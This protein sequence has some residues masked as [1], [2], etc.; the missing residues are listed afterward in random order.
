MTVREKRD[1]EDLVEWALMHQVPGLGLVGGGG[2]AWGQLAALGTRVQ[3]SR[4][5]TPPPSAAEDGDVAMV[6][7]AICGLPDE[8]AALV[9]RYGKTGR[10]PEGADIGDP[11]PRQ[12]RERNGRLC[13]EY[14]IP[15]N[16][17][18]PRVGPM[19]DMRTWSREMEIVR[20]D[21][22]Q[23]TLWREAL[24]SMV[25]PLNQHLRT[26]LA[27]GP[28][29][30]ET[31]WVGAPPAAAEAEDLPIIDD[32]VELQDRQRTVGEVR[33]AAQAAVQSRATDWTVPKKGRGPRRR[34]Q[35]D[36]APPNRGVQKPRSA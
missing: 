24:A 22:A 7:Q 14:A 11:V 12:L 23:W 9:V 30:P 35:R 3:T 10:R 34:R 28:A 2:D 20:F 29:A 18:S 32:E 15:G 31:P 36:D 5:G 27:T 26:H 16:N 21:R 19:L 1:I 13:W 33:D 6:L 25:E 17:R 8:A 4:Y